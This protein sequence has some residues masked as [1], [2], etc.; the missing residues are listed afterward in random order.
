VPQTG[1]RG[2][3]LPGEE[4]GRLLAQRRKEDVLDLFAN[5]PDAS[6]RELGLLALR[7]NEIDDA[8]GLGDLCAGQ[9]LLENQ[10]R[11]FYVGKA[12]TAYRRAAARAANDVDRR[13]ADG[14]IARLVQW[15]AE[16]ALRL[17]DARNVAVALWAAAEIP[18][19]EQ[20][21]ELRDLIAAL[22]PQYPVHSVAARDVGDIRGT[23]GRC[24]AIT[25]MVDATQ[26]RPGRHREQ[27]AASR[28][29]PIKDTRTRKS[30]FRGSD[31]LSDIYEAAEIEKGTP[32]RRSPTAPVRRKAPSRRWDRPAISLSRQDTR[33][34]EDEFW[35]ATGSRIRSEVAQVCAA[36]WA[37]STCATTTNSASGRH[38]ELPVALLR[39]RTGRAALRAGSP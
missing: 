6:I 10:L 12:L 35:P 19:Q 8:F 5:D 7:R 1:R 32:V 34:H 13:I 31:V 28:A 3:D 20:N 21:Q 9:I 27:S 36:G 15:V 38:Q 23:Q 33:T 22:V 24:R 26:V 25:P 29:E 39:Q 2:P 11:V 16:M 4:G 14:A 17:P 37:W 30:A 18:A